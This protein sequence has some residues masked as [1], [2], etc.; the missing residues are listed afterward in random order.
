[1]NRE[2]VERIVNAARLKGERPNLAYADLAKADLANADLGGA[3]LRVADLSGADLSGAILAFACLERANLSRANLTD[4]CLSFADLRGANTA[5]SC[6]PLWCG[7]PRIKLDRANALRLIYHA[8]NQ[9]YDDPLIIEAL[10]P[11]LP[12]CAEFIKEVQTDAPTICWEHE[13]EKK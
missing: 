7:G 3:N 8:V 11:L 1:M 9:D 12:L 10:R 6:L 13:K 4:A 5:F 2:E